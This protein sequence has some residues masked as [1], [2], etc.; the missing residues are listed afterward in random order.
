MMSKLL[1]NTEEASDALTKRIR[2]FKISNSQGE[3]VDKATSLLGGAVKR[4]AQINRVPQNIVRNMPQIMQTTSVPK[5]NNTFE[6]VETSRFVNDCEP[7]LHVGV[8]GQFNV[9]T[10]FSIAE[11]KYTST[12][13]A[14]KWNGVSNK[15]SKSTFITVGSEKKPVCWNCGGPHRLPDCTLPKNQEII[16]NVFYFN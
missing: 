13:E 8:T 15:G 6:L 9:N 3:N 2:D 14:H 11:Q 12:M 16:I 1:S 4:L 10:I 7:T 5:F